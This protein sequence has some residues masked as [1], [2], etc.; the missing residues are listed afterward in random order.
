MRGMEYHFGRN[1][2][3]TNLVLA[4]PGTWSTENPSQPV[5]SGQYAGRAT[6]QG[7]F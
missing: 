4:R 2:Q 7:V 3:L 5:A 1:V 6:T